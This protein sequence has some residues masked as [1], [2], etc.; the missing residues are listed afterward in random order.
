[1]RS[2]KDYLLLFLKGIGMGGADVVPG[3]SGGTIAFITG[4]YEELLQSINSFDAEAFRL[5]FSF[6]LPQF[7]KHVNG[8]FLLAL[9]SGILVS[10]F[11]LAKLISFLL[12]NHPI[13]LWSFFFGLIIISS[14]T[15]TKEITKWK[16]V[17]ILSGL[18]G[19]V[20]AYGIT[21]ITPASTPDA[22]WF[23]FLSGSLAICA[24]I[25]P[26]ISGSFIMLILGKYAFIMAAVNEMKVG[27]LAIFILG[28][29]TGLFTFSRAISWFLTKFHNHAIALLAGFMIGSLNKIWPWKKAILF[30]WRNGEQVTIQEKNLLPMEYLSETGQEPLFVQA[31]F[32]MAC[33]F[34]IVVIMEKIAL[35]IKKGRDKVR[36][37]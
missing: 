33:G 11:T 36:V 19:I 8:N 18:L 1:M 23:I 31:I 16:F 17:T 22:W 9:V 10:V 15:V 7:W 27:T 24:M 30:D 20:I 34:M 6:K 28:C 21:T 14:L 37:S 35:A 12:E 29:I 3:V 4:I 32:F 26:G 13:Q 5:L 25:L 2:L